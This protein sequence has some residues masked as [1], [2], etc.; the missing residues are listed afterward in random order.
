MHE[1]GHL[2][3][4]ETQWFMQ[5]R[6]VLLG[7]E[8]AIHRRKCMCIGYM[9]YTGKRLG[10]YKFWRHRRRYKN[11]TK[12]FLYVQKRNYNLEFKYFLKQLLLLFIWWYQTKQHLL[13]LLRNE[14]QVGKDSYSNGCIR[15]DKSGIILKGAGI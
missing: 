13:V 7:R 8:K 4:F 12:W 14:T 15:K 6:L 2:E 3:Y 5:L 9:N 10:T 11:N 1:V